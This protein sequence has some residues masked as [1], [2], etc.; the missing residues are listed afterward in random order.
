[1]K[2]INTDKINKIDEK[3]NVKAKNKKKNTIIN[4]MKKIGQKSKK[5]F[6]MKYNFK[7]MIICMIITFSFGIVLGGIIMYSNNYIGRHTT[8]SIN[9]FISTYND[10][11]DNYY[12]E[13]KEDE[14][15]EAGIKG[16][17]KYLGD[18]YSTILQKDDA[19]EF[20]D[21]VEGVYHGIG[22]QVKYDDKLK[23]ILIGE[24]FADSPAEASGLKEGDVLLKVNGD[25]IKNL[26]LT[27]ISERV[28]GEDGTE[29]ELTVGRSNE[30]IVLKI[31]RGSIDNI[32][33]TSEIIEK[34]EHKIGYL[35]V[36]VF[37]ANTYNQFKHE[38][39]NL[40]KDNIESLIIDVRGNS[41]G[42]LTTVTDILSLFNKKD[43]VL[44]QLK[45]KD[46]I[47]IVKDKTDDY[48]EYP[49]IVLTDSRSAS[50]S[51]VLVGCFKET[52]GGK[53]VGTKT[54]GKG[55]VQKLYQLSSGTVVKY[56]YQEWLTPNGSYI[57]TNGIAPDIEIKYEYNE[58]KDN[59][60]DKAIEELLNNK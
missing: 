46:E 58:K 19:K 3:K 35:Y 33:V 42:Y 9:E 44:Y 38:L 18:P 22:A 12:K 15:L 48:R 7:E 23:Q 1:M 55:K 54:F 8:N 5:K 45:T 10:I 50:A 14:L 30:E 29:V 13:V 16:M 39:D 20:N 6:K 11:V 41:G 26:S 17:L 24:V 60:L 28:K 27:E 56:T 31:K 37:A 34:K 51:E 57:D 59:Q 43:S 47:E 32:S 53:S 52:Y 4:K 40:E 36:S 25:D 21:D 2:K 49:V